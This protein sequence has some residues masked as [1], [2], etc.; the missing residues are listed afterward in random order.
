[1]ILDIEQLVL[2]MF[3]GDDSEVRGD[4]TYNK[5][6][7]RELIDIG[8]EYKVCESTN[9]IGEYVGYITHQ[10]GWMPDLAKRMVKTLSKEWREREKFEESVIGLADTMSVVTSQTELTTGIDA[11]HDYYACST[12]A[13]YTKEELMQIFGYLKNVK[14]ASW[15]TLCST[16]SRVY[17]EAY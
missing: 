13:L 4:F 8:W 2:A 16:S 7:F 10:G 3:Q 15:N 1:M 17:Y 14:S 6:A 9:G 12:D 5:S 11:A